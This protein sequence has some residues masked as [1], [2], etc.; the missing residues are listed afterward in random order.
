M[1]I[2]IE[3]PLTKTSREMADIQQYLLTVAR[4]FW[5]RFGY[6]SKPHVAGLPDEMCFRV[7]HWT[8]RAQVKLGNEPDP[9]V[10]FQAAWNKVFANIRSCI[11]LADQTGAPLDRALAAYKGEGIGTLPGWSWPWR[12]KPKL[13][14]Q[15][16]ATPYV[17]PKM[18]PTPGYE[19]R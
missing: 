4:A 3:N 6:K 18:E 16:M 19:Q 5:V 17:Q 15:P 9:D 7:G 1:A 14:T 8:Y 2:E 11:E 12:K 10:R 13:Q